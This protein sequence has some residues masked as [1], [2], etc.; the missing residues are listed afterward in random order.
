MILRGLAPARP[1]RGL[2]AL[3]LGWPL[4]EQA[5][6]HRRPARGGRASS[7]AARTALLEQVRR[8]HLRF[9]LLHADPCRTTGPWPRGRRLGACSRNTRTTRGAGARRAASAVG[10]RSAMAEERSRCRPLR[11]AHG[12]RRAITSHAHRPCARPPIAP[13]RTPAGHAEAP[14]SPGAAAPA[15]RRPPR[16]RSAT[17][18]SS[19]RALPAQGSGPRRWCSGHACSPCS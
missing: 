12:E 9:A 3:P 15:Q 16:P 10:G 13:P 1:G 8:L 2:G 11:I 17:L 19:R 6:A 4:A 18:P 14:S 5:T 7:A